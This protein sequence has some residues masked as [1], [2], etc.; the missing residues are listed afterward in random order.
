M[1]GSLVNSSPSMLNH[2]PGEDA[3]HTCCGLAVSRNVISDR[4]A[5]AS[6]S[7]VACAAEP[8]LGLVMIQMRVEC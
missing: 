6:R 8:A 7:S 4:S 2:M 1:T 3:M 5:I